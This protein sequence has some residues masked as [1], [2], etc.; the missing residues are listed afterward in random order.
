[1]R[2]YQNFEQLDDGKITYKYKR[3]VIN[4]GNIDGGLKA[5]WDI[6]RIG[7]KRLRLMGLR[8]LT[9]E[10]INPYDQRYKRARE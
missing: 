10:D 5:P 6:H 1:M 2:E 4:L 3:M 9:Y 8:N 7:V